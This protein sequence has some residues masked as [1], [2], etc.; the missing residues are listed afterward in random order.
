M[1]RTAISAT[2]P[3]RSGDEDPPPRRR[4]RAGSAR[5]PR[6]CRLHREGVGVGMR[7]GRVVNGGVR[8]PRVLLGV[9]FLGHGSIPIRLG[10]IVGRGVFRNTALR[11]GVC[12][13]EAGGLASFCDHVEVAPGGAG[14]GAARRGVSLLGG[15]CRELAGP[16]RRGESRNARTR[17]RGARDLQA[18]GSCRRPAACQ[19]GS[20]RGCFLACHPHRSAA[21]RSARI[22]SKVGSR[23]STPVR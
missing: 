12:T 16:K 15:G 19:T 13:R 8:R 9:V 21:S 18:G 1:S 4:A 11:P 20:G 17:A 2:R 3:Q 6:G 10:G 5:G 23:S 22:C 7:A 14:V